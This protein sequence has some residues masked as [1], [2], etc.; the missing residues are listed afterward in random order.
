MAI[1]GVILV[2]MVLCGPLLCAASQAVNDWFDRH[3]DAVNEPGRP[4]PSGRMPGHWGLGVAILWT[5]LALLC[6]AALGT[7]GV[8]RGGP[9]AAARL[10]LQRAA[11]AAQAERLVGKPG[12]RGVLRRIRLGHGR[13]DHGRRNHA[14]RRGSS[15]S[16][17]STASA[18]TA[19]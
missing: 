8:L 2:G 9:G 12:V 17:R 1:G 11:G 6:A 14:V 13:R 7:L 10:G 15:R 16:R 4:I 19:S 3:V 18:R 5:L